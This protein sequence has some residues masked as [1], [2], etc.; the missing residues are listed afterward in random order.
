MN[1]PRGFRLDKGLQS[2]IFYIVFRTVNG[3]DILHFT[4]TSLFILGGMAQ[5]KTAALLIACIVAKKRILFN[6]EA[7]EKRLK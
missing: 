4:Q 7:L 2:V 3:T 6:R 1:P 5:P